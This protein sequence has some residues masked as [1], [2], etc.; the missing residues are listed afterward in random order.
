MS[1]FA[2]AILRCIFPF[3]D[4]SNVRSQSQD[5]LIYSWARHNSRLMALRSLQTPDAFIFEPSKAYTATYTY[6]VQMQLSEQIYCCINFEALLLSLKF[7]RP[8]DSKLLM[9]HIAIRMN[10]YGREIFH[11]A[12]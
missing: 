2:D 7:T 3:F 11:T 10:F 6:A 8:R 1:S 4:L 12:R 9:H 5:I